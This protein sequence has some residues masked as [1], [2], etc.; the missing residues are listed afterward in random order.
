MSFAAEIDQFAGE[1]VDKIERIRRIFIG[2]LCFAIVER[3]PVRTGFHNGN[4]QPSIG[5]PEMD[6]VPR[7]SK[8]GAYIKRLVMST[9]EKLKGDEAF[10]FSNN[11]PAILRLEYEG[12]SSQAPAGMVRVSAAEAG[13]IINQAIREGEL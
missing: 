13:Q 6:V 4:W 5:A 2:K 3:T 1:T 12:W 7:K 9:L 10:Y 11:G 8:D